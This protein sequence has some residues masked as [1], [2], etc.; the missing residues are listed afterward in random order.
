MWRLVGIERANRL[1]GW[2][3][4]LHA[5]GPRP[6]NEMFA[7]EDRRTAQRRKVAVPAEP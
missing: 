6:V 3:F 7:A 4:I 2:T 1:C 5:L